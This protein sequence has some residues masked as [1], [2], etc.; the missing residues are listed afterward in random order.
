MGSLLDFDSQRL[1]HLINGSKWDELKLMD[2][3]A[4]NF[5]NLL[6][7]NNLA[8]DVSLLIDESGFTKK[9]KKS[10]GVKHQ[11]NGQAGKLDNCQVGV[12]GALNAGSLTSII[13]SI[14]HIAHEGKTKIDLAKDIINHVVYHLKIIPKCINADAFY[15]RDTALLAYMQS[16]NLK[17]IFD[18][19]EGHKIY[20]EPFQMRVP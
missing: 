20:L 8:D 2:S 16:K 11:Y 14:L 3:I 5:I 17:F 13:K 9:G 18:V 4:H 12:F 6:S 15:G 7:D 19:P 10:A 1:N